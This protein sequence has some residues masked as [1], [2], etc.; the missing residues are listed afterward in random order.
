MLTLKVG[1]KH[2]ALVCFIF[3]AIIFPVK[4]Q[5]GKPYKPSLAGI[6]LSYEDY[7]S[8][9]TQDAGLYHSHETQGRWVVFTQNGQKVKIK[10]DESK[11]WGFRDH[12]GYC[13]RA[14][15]GKFFGIINDSQ[16]IAI[17]SQLFIP[18]V[19]PKSSLAI[20]HYKSEYVAIS[21]GP[22]A[23]MVYLRRFEM[24]DSLNYWFTQAGEDDL[25]VSLNLNN[26]MK[27]VYKLSNL[28][29]NLEIINLYNSR[30]AKI[31]KSQLKSN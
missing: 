6:F 24:T 8:G 2:I 31:S 23:P 3:N 18:K 26:T 27:S 20:P 28:K 30:R 4:S 7:L 14:Y 17:Y 19:S 22:T 12:F 5:I 1:I 9:S 10:P 29:K 11:L 13:Y 21:K 25:I 16:E 15:N